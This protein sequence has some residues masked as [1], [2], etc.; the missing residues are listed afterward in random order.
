MANSKPNLKDQNVAHSRYII[1]DRRDVSPT[2]DNPS[3]RFYVKT[4]EAIREAVDIPGSFHGVFNPNS[5]YVRFERPGGSD[6]DRHLDLFVQSVNIPGKNITSQALRIYGPEREMPTGV[7]YSGDIEMRFTLTQDFFAY[8][9]I[10]EWMNNIVGETTSNVS[11]YD[12]YKCNLLI[13]PA[14]SLGALKQSTTLGDDP[15]AGD[16]SPVIFVVED[17]WPKTMSQ[18]ELNQES[19]N[20]VAQFTLSLSF[21][22]WHYISYEEAARRTANPASA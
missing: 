6:L 8:K 7:S 20:S 19:K 22:K 5:F 2:S 16:Q 9:W 13:A 11:Y 12:M 14:V 21:R 3:N 10:M 1:R 15:V 4:D 17:V 18:I